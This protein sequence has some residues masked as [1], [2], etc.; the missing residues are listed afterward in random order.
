MYK[1]TIVGKTK[2]GK[3]LAYRVMDGDALYSIYFKK[4]GQVPKA[5]SGHWND[6]RQ[7]ENAITCYL[8]RDLLCP[9]DQAKKQLKT[10]LS[11]SKKRPSRLKAKS[12]A[13][14]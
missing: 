5:L 1:E 2:D 12:D 7:I 14:S 11:D 6:T 3:E 8:N 9:E 4:G 13:K 10:N